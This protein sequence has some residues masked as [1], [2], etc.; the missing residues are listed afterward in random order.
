MIKESILKLQFVQNYFRSN[1]GWPL[2]SKGPKGSRILVVNP[3]WDDELVSC[4]GT[5]YPARDRVSLFCLDRTRH[6]PYLARPY[7]EVDELH[8]NYDTIFLPAP[9]DD[10]PDHVEASKIAIPSGSE[11][12]AY[13]NY[14]P[15]ATNCVVDI[16]KVAYLKYNALGKMQSE[17]VN[18]RNWTHYAKGRDA[19]ASRH[20]H[21]MG[22]RYAELFMVMPNNEFIEFRKEFFKCCKG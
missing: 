12:W 15:I 9:W 19:Y 22:K 13:Q 3:H 14:D 6:N 20:L 21:M 8:G 1:R 4:F 16:S 5:L 18:Q 7:T 10:H 11:V 2:L 17:L